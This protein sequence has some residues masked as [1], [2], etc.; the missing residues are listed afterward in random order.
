MFRDQLFFKFKVF[1]FL[2]YTEKYEF[3]TRRI[4]IQL[5]QNLSCLL[6]KEIQ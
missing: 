2:N 6:R 5:I 3:M 1:I 4:N